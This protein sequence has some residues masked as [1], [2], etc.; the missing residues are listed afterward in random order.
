MFFRVRKLEVPGALDALP[1]RDE[2]LSVPE[3]HFVSGARIVPPFPEGLEKAVFGLGCF[4]G[5]EKKFWETPGVYATAVGYAGGTTPNPTYREVCSG[6][7][8]HAEVVLVVFDPAK[9]SYGDLLK[10]FWES[11]DPTQGMR[12]GNDVGT[13]YRSAIYA[14]S[15]AR[16]REA[17]ASR[18]AYQ[19]VLSE[20][21]FGP[22]T[23][24]IREAPEFYYAEE[25]HQQYLAKNPDGYCGIGGTGVACPAGLT[26][27]R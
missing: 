10:V 26:K 19:R 22:V 3:R 5:A 2:P 12:Q 7:T 25:Y 11:H 24:E 9:V 6:G 1:G 21:G 15:E 4:W 13:Q 20:A 18:E 14:F 27:A 17:E 23:T 8:G 16:L